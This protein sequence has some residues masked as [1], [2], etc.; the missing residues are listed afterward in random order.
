MV[1]TGSC[2]SQKSGTYTTPSDTPASTPSDDLWN[3]TNA[4]LSDMV[5]KRA[6]RLEGLVS[7]KH[8]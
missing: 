6:R 8:I 2:S 4:R 5:Y 1:A 7:I 3:S